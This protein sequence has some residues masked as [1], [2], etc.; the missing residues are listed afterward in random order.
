MMIQCKPDIRWKARKAVTA[1]YCR[2]VGVQARRDVVKRSR[3]RYLIE[4]SFN[5]H[6][7]HKKGTPSKEESA[8]VSRGLERIL[9]PL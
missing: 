3:N 9:F 1:I 5:L 8:I 2:V 7:L 6:I 4:S